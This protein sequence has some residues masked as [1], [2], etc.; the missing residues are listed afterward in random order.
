LHFII[1]GCAFAAERYSNICWVHTG[2]MDLSGVNR[3]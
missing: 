1:L 3:A 2:R